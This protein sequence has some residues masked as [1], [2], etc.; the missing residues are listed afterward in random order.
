MKVLVPGDSNDVK[1]CVREALSANGPVYLRISASEVPDIID[2]S[3]PHIT[4]EPYLIS[5]G[6]DIAVFT[7]GITLQIGS[8]LTKL[9]RE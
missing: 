9:L 5:E 3:K 4:G 6:K 8:Q 7:T 2:I 1:N